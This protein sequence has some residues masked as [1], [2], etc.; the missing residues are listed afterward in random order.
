MS[1]FIIEIS[2]VYEKLKYLKI[3][4]SPGMDHI[5]PRI[6]K[7]NSEELSDVLCKLNNL[8]VYKGALSDD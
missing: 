5:N 1:D 3:D 2:D 8:S 6:L 4:K 7:E